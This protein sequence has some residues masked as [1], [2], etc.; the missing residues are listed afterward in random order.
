M[1]SEECDSTT[2]QAPYILY[3]KSIEGVR[4][5]YKISNQPRLKR[6]SKSQRETERKKSNRPYYTG[7]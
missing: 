4:D 7:F 1:N 3:P 6:L 5:K 2:M